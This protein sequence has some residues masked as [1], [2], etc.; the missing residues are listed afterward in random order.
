MCVVHKYSISIFAHRVYQT[1]DHTFALTQE[2]EQT[3]GF[4]LYCNRTIH[5]WGRF[6]IYIIHML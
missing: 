6:F 1:F 2:Q 5:V 3:W 4:F